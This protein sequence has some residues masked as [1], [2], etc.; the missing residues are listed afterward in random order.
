M[1]FFQVPIR[2]PRLCT[3]ATSGDDRSKAWLTASSRVANPGLFGSSA[4][5]PPLAGDGLEYLDKPTVF[6]N[7]A[8]V[9]GRASICREQVRQRSLPTEN[10]ESA[11]ETLK[12]P[13]D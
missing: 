8:L 12:P 1:R 11:A 7:A 2:S 10:G 13:R 4:G 9:R 3:Y 5:G 6:C